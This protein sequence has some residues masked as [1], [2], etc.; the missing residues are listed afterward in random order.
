MGREKQQSQPANF[1]PAGWTWRKQE[2]RMDCTLLTQMSL[3][4]E[5]RLIGMGSFKLKIELARCKPRP[6]PIIHK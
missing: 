5:H 1:G 4:E 3:R 6:R 2:S